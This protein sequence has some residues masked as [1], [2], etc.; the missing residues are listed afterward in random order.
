[1]HRNNPHKHN[2]SWY[3]QCVYDVGLFVFVYN[4]VQ[5]IILEEAHVFCCRLIHLFSPL[6]FAGVQAHLFLYSKRRKSKREIRKADNTG[7]CTAV[8]ARGVV[9]QKADCYKAWASST[10]GFRKYPELRYW[11]YQGE[12]DSGKKP[13]AKNLVTLPL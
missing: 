3:V 8:A 7:H 1:M 10:A 12:D 11:Y 13:E 4:T 2:L 5:N 9:E 6:A